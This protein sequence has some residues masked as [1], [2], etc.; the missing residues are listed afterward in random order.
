MSKIMKRPMFRRGGEV[1]E[2][3]VNMAMPRR[4]YAESN[5]DDLKKQFP[6]QSG[7]IDKAIADTALMQGFV[8]RPGGDPLAN[9]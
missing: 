2:G 7:V 1:T 6:E 3:I 5:Y 4:Q 8:G 9:L